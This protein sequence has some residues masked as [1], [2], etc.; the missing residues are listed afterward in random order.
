[1]TSR[2]DPSVDG[3]SEQTDPRLYTEAEVLAISKAVIRLC[4]RDARSGQP[5][6]RLYTKP[7]VAAI[8]SKRL[9]WGYAVGLALVLL[10]GIIYL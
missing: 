10:M 3:K 7:E 9:M 8:I 6:D 4:P 5:G 1:M 2:I